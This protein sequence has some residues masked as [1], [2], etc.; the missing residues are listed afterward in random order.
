MDFLIVF[1]GNPGDEYKKTRHNAGFL[2]ADFFEENKNIVWKQK[3][4]A[5]F[6]QTNIS[7]N[8]IFLLKPQ[9]FMNKSGE[10][11]V[12]AMQFFKINPKNIIVIHDDLETKFGEISFKKG[13]GL[14]GHNGLKSIAQKIGTKDFLRLK[15]GIGRPQKG[16]VSSFVLGKF[17]PKELDFLPIILEETSAIIEELIQKDFKQKEFKKQAF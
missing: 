5:Q 15:I 9:T 7:G 8:K 12:P 17:T 3:F 2:V 1:L 4:K 10:S 14:A 13:G 6:A 16:S 11:V